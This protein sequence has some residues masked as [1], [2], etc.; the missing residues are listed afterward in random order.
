MCCFITCIIIFPHI[1]YAGDLQD[2]QL[3]APQYATTIKQMTGNWQHAVDLLSATEWKTLF[4]TDLLPFPLHP[5]LPCHQVSKEAVKLKKASVPYRFS[6]RFANV[7]QK[8]STPEVSLGSHTVPPPV[9]SN[10][11]QN[12]YFFFIKGK[13]GRENTSYRNFKN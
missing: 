3:G 1:F 7:Q 11:P 6:I 10:T 5:F 2:A 8:L 4:G 9:P 12:I 13:A